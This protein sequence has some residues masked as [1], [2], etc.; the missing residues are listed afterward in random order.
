MRFNNVLYI[1]WYLHPPKFTPKHYNSPPMSTDQ[2]PNLYDLYDKVLLLPPEERSPFIKEQ[3]KDYPE[4]QQQLKSMSN[5]DLIDT[6]EVLKPIGSVALGTELVGKRVGSYKILEKIGAGGMGA[7]FL[8]EHE[9]LKNKDAIKVSLLGRLSTGAQMQRFHSERRVL[10]HLNHPNIAHIREAGVTEYGLP[11]FAMEYVDGAPLHEYADTNKLMIRE[12]LELFLDV[13]SAVQYAHNNF[14]VHRDLKPSNI[15]VT[16]EGQI[17]LLDFGIAKVLDENELLQSEKVDSEEEL[18]LTP[19]YASPEQKRGEPVT[20]SSDVYSL[21]VILYEL[22]V[23]CRPLFETQKGLNGN[24]GEPVPCLPSVLISQRGNQV[25]TPEEYSAANI[26][27]LRRSDT[28]K[29]AKTLEGDLDA[30]V[31][32]ALMDKIEDRFESPAALMEDIR[33]YLDDYPVVARSTSSRYSAWKFLQR[34]KLGVGA[35]LVSVI[36][37][38]I[39]LTTALWQAGVAANERDTAVREATTA[40]QV[41]A[42]LINLFDQSDPTV[43]YGDSLTVH[44]VLDKGTKTINEG[45]ADQPEV[46]AELLSALSRIYANLGEYEQVVQ[47]SEEDIRIRSEELGKEDV[48]LL[49]SMDIL[50]FAKYKIGEPDAADSI[51]QEAF[52]LVDEIE[53]ENDEVLSELL[54]SYASVVLERGQLE[55]ADSLLRRSIAIS[56]KV[57]EEE[58]QSTAEGLRTLAQALVRL[59]KPDEAETAVRESIGIT[60]RLLGEEHYSLLTSNM[61]LAEVLITKGQYPEAISVYKSTIDRFKSIYG[62][63]H[64]E[65][66]TLYTGYANVLTLTGNYPDAEKYNRDALAIAEENMGKYNTSY[67]T[68]LFNLGGLLGYMNDLNQSE[69]VMREAI[70]LAKVVYGEQHYGMAKMYAQVAIVLRLKG[71]FEEAEAMLREVLVIVENKAGKENQ[72]YTI[73]LGRLANLMR[74]QGDNDEAEA[75]FRETITLQEITMP[76]DNPMR[77]EARLYFSG[78]LANQNKNMEEAKGYAKQAYDMAKNEL[79]PDHYIIPLTRDNYVNVLIRKADYTEAESLMVQI[80][81]QQVASAGKMHEST[82]TA[83]QRLIGLY[84]LKGDSLKAKEYMAHFE[85]E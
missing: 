39:G 34:N 53:P 52:K 3:C 38:L 50:G 72:E 42:F 19:E 76:P 55:L 66:G 57:H 29:L 7:V 63:R 49:S 30:I 44:V 37:L 22:C 5:P 85:S 77:L 82:Q 6:W 56:R 4:I 64:P 28:K 60:T 15:L 48:Y 31:L 33:R 81:N 78:L 26:A 2:R 1:P 46:R 62:E 18:A 69:E 25:E 73:F 16:R 12:R 13:C 8:G 65:I 83:L 36:A 9:E 68:A 47:L 32:K 71:Q 11:Y 14:I 27:I 41:T 59:G 74:I 23:G 84:E 75:L 79:P 58:D 17:K 70:E 35:A 21:G 54:D 10:A 24:A 45:L 40:D 67:I 80:Y 20:S 51:F 43:S 61:I